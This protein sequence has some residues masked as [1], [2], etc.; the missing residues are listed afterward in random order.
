MDKIGG[1]GGRVT[2]SRVPWGHDDELHVPCTS[3]VRVPPPPT[4]TRK[5]P[6][7]RGLSISV[8]GPNLTDGTVVVWRLAQSSPLQPAPQALPFA[9]C[10]GQRENML[11]IKTGGYLNR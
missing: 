1:K 2:D 7:S 3:T 8:N 5:H 6:T 4:C 11:V 10:G 9:G